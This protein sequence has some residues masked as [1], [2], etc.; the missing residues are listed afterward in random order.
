MKDDGNER[1]GQRRPAGRNALYIQCLPGLFK[2]HS[3]KA[4]R[5]G[6]ADISGKT[7]P[8]HGT[9]SS[10]IW[11]NKRKFADWRGERP[12]VGEN[13]NLNCPAGC[14]LCAEHR[15]ATCCNPAGDHSAVQYELYLLFCGAGRGAGSVLRHGKTLDR[16]SDGAGKDTL[17][18]SGGEPTVRDDLPEIVAY[19][20]QVGCKYVQLN[21]NGLRPAEDEGV[22]KASGGCG[23]FVL[24]LCSL[25]AWTMPYMKN[26]AAARCWK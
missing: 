7:C 9:F 22:C 8:D 11:R 2:T 14:G 15:R 20:K 21:S 17:Q 24:Y 10:V 6:R 12:A 1:T 26:C 25:T 18:L 19:A 13:E 16:R 23:T 3:G 4:G 5:A